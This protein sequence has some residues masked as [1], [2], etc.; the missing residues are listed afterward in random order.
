MLA[1]DPVMVT[2]PPVV[3]ASVPPEKLSVPCSTVSV[4]EDKSVSASA[5]ESVFAAVKA[6]SVLM[7]VVKVVVDVFE[8]DAPFSWL[9]GGS[10]VPLMANDNVVVDVAPRLSVSS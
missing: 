8:K 3:A 9:T 6:K 4:T 1:C 5:T 10:F 2:V 7:A